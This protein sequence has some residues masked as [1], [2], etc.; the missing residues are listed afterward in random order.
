MIDLLRSRRLPKQLQAY[1]DGE[2]N[3]DYSTA[4]MDKRMSLRWMGDW[5]QV[6]CQTTVRRTTEHVNC[7]VW[8]A[9]E[10]TPD[11]GPNGCHSILNRN[12]QSLYN[13][14]GTCNSLKIQTRLTD[15]HYKKGMSWQVC[16]TLFPSMEVVESML[17]L[18]LMG[19][20]EV[21]SATSHEEIMSGWFAD[22]VGF[23]PCNCFIYLQLTT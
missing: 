12:P 15:W 4:L 9:A 19:E 7:R 21:Q 5:L 17:S 11:V 13:V 20:G 8:A 18:R 14:V 16:H 10:E 23:I 6:S 1:L 3:S 2:S 22:K